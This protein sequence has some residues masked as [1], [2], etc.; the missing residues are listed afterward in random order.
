M[1]FLRSFSAV[2]IASIDVI[3]HRRVDFAGQLD[4][5]RRE[6]VFARFPRQ[7]ERI[8]RD[9][10][11][12]ES[13][14]R[15]ERHEAEGLG[16]RG[17]DHFPDVH[18]HAQAEHFQ[19][20]DQRDVDAA[21][22]IFQQLGHFR[23]ARGADRNHLGNDRRVDRLRRAAAGWVD[24]ANDLGN[25][26]Q[27]ELLVAGIFAFRR[28]S[29]E[30]VAGHVF[31]LRAGGDG[32]LQPALF[33]NGQHQFFGGAGIRRGFEHHQLAALQVRLDH[34]RGV[35]HVAQIGF[36]A[37]IEWR[38]NADDDGVGILQPVASVVALKCLLL[39]NC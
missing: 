18:A 26:R 15:I 38:R 24:A 5:A 30:E 36:A 32:A 6:I 35:F 22:D 4:E 17:V 11:A 23:G 21:E 37:L 12:A 34:D 33:E 16:G 19:F 28:E 8:D 25:L 2:A 7:I 10:M 1:D 31:V 13:G 20:V 27:A 3:R 14:A 29:Q 9:A 39:T